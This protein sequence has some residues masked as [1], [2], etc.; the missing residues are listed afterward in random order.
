ML[1]GVR[2]NLDFAL[3]HAFKAL[4]NIEQVPIA[5]LRAAFDADVH[6]AAFERISSGKGTK[7][8]HGTN[9]ILGKNETYGLRYV[10]NGNHVG[11]VICH[12]SNTQ[13]DSLATAS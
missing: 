9:I 6:I 10:S 13:G 4:L 7:K 1:D 3:Q 5:Y 8:I 12:A 11:I 2:D